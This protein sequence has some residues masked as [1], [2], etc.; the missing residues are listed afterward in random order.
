MARWMHVVSRSRSRFNGLVEPVAKLLH[1]VDDGAK[2]EQFIEEDARDRAAYETLAERVLD[3]IG[4]AVERMI[5][6]EL[7][8]HPEL[9]RSGR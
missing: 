3:A 9:L 7:R 6:R 5:T 4:P 2:K 1:S 8:E